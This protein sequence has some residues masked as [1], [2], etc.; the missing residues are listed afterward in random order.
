MFGFLQTNSSAAAPPGHSPGSRQAEQTSLGEAPHQ[1]GS[2]VEQQ[3][4]LGGSLPPTRARAGSRRRHRPSPSRQP[5][6]GP[7]SG[8]SPSPPGS[9]PDGRCG[10]QQHPAVLTVPCLP[11]ATRRP[12]QSDTGTTAVRTPLA[13]GIAKPLSPPNPLT[14]GIST[15]RA[16]SWSP[17]AGWEACLPDAACPCQRRSGLSASIFPNIRSKCRFLADIGLSVPYWSLFG[18]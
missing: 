8:P 11:M 4:Q 1:Q 7:D 16:L 14:G 10:T 6:L 12:G 3:R 18:L 17:A 15:R 2:H 9:K 13:A 5:G